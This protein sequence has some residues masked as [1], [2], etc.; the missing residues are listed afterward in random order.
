MKKVKIAI[1]VHHGRVSPLFDVAGQ[2]I[3][4]DSTMSEGRTII[5]IPQNTSISIIDTLN[6]AEVDV[7]ICSAISN[8]F[9]K[10]LQGK[11]INL[12]PGVIGIADEVIDAFLNDELFIDKF[13]MPGCFWRR[14]YRG[15][16]CPYYKEI[17]PGNKIK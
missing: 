4:I 8:V 7:V 17:N 6:E 1:P 16:Q 13:A 12:V 9:A 2:F 15:R 14:R 11:G 5:Q 3:L 10:M